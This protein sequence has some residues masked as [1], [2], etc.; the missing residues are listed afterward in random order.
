MM[1]SPVPQTGPLVLR[2]Q[3]AAVS[4]TTPAATFRRLAVGPGTVPVVTAR[5]SVV[6]IITMPVAFKPRLAAASITLPAESLQSL[7]VGSRAPRVDWTQRLAG[8]I[9]TS[10]APIPRQSGA[11]LETRLQP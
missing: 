8:E 6:A 1:A 7:V 5:R 11:G 10:P 4:A 9:Q 3:W 2:P